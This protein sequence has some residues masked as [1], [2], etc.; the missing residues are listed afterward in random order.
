MVDFSLL[1]RIIQAA[2]SDRSSDQAGVADDAGFVFK[3]L[4][5][6]CIVSA[7]IGGDDLVPERDRGFLGVSLEFNY[8]VMI[9]F[10]ESDQSVENGSKFVYRVAD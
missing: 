7:C 3:L 1:Q 4:K 10:R 9:H 6:V 5:N 2:S 8:S